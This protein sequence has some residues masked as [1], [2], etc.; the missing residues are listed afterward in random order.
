MDDIYFVNRSS[1]SVLRILCL[2]KFLQTGWLEYFK[3]EK[4]SFS[5]CSFLFYTF[6]D[7]VVDWELRT[8]SLPKNTL[9]I[10]IFRYFLKRPISPPPS[11]L[12]CSGLIIFQFCVTVTWLSVSDGKKKKGYTNLFDLYF[13]LVISLVPA[14]TPGM[15]S[16]T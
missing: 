5:L 15:V 11:F 14:G 9:R 16:Q 7:L 8:Q 6:C 4:K 13:H 12:L 10:V 2:F 1:L 3:Q